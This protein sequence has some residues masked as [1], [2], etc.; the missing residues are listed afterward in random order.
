M[1]KCDFEVF[2]MWCLSGINNLIYAHF[3]V[4]SGKVKLSIIS[5]NKDHTVFEWLFMLKHMN[6]ITYIYPSNIP[7]QFFC[8]CSKLFCYIRDFQWKPKGTKHSAVSTIFNFMLQLDASLVPL[9]TED[10]PTFCSQSIRFQWNSPTIPNM[11]FVALIDPHFCWLIQQLAPICPWIPITIRGKKRYF[12]W[13]KTPD[14]S[15]N[16]GGEQP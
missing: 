15:A 16:G 10:L 12:P 3:L 11:I 1:W 14:R 8:L 9:F 5:R 7:S 4:L 13:P 6:H 2:F